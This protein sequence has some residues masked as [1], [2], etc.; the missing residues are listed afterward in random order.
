M[1]SDT[2]GH[3]EVAGDGSDACGVDERWVHS[4]T[5]IEDAEPFSFTRRDHRATRME[6]ASTGDR[7]RAGRPSAVDGGASLHLDTAN[8]QVL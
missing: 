2:R 8:T 6:A 5:T 3:R 4:E 7:A 1:V